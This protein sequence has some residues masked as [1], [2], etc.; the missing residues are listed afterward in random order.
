MQIATHISPQPEG[1]K[2]GEA[3]NG[4]AWTEG[5]RE[6]ESREEGKDFIKVERCNRERERERESSPNLASAS[7]IPY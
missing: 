3:K 1:L 5:G 6:S 4:H 2:G 7:S